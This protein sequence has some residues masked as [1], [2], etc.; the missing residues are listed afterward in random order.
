MKSLIGLIF[1]FGALCIGCGQKGNDC[2]DGVCAKAVTHG[3][4]D[5]HC[6]C[7]CENCKDCLKKVKK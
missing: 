2:N 3:P 6:H 4:H 1:I 5:D 7:D